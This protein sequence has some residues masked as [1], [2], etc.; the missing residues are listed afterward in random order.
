MDI[1]REQSL[2]PVFDSGNEMPK[3]DE[4][5]QSYSTNLTSHRTCKFSGVENL[6]SRKGSGSGNPQCPTSAA[7]R[8]SQ[9]RSKATRDSRLVFVLHGP[10]LRE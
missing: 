2:S 4:V 5:E 8:Y 10:S 1:S 7:V 6:G 9:Y 3:P